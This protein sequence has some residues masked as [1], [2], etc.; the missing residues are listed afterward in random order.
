[1][2]AVGERFA[3]GEYFLAELMMA[4]EVFKQATVLLDPY[5]KAGSDEERS[6]RGT[7]VMAT[8]KGDIHEIGKNVVV[9]MLEAYGFEVYDLG[10]DVEPRLI[11][12]KVAEIQP[13]FLGLSARSEEHTS[14]LQSR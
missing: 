1:M 10:V 6:D 13:Q 5:I 12:D 7:V 11:V 14:E 9:M 8:P 2:V 3:A 4:G